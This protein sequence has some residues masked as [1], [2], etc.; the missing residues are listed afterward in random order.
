MEKDSLQP[1]QI[2]KTTTQVLPIESTQEAF[3]HHFASIEDATI[4]T[5]EELRQFS[6]EHSSSAIA[7]AIQMQ[8]ASDDLPSVYELEDAIRELQVGRSSIGCLPA[9]FLRADP[10]AAATLLFPSLLALFR[11]FQQPI[12]WKG[13]SIFRFSKGKVPGPHRQDTERF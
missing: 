4:Q 7:A 8:I 13:G 10:A 3:L 5:E 6:R 12:S 9:E 2:S 11:F 1:P